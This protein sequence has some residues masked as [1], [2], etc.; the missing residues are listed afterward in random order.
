MR[1]RT[2]NVAAEP[3]LKEAMSDYVKDDMEVVRVCMIE[4]DI[5]SDEDLNDDPMGHFTSASAAM[6][7]AP[8][9]EAEV[10]LHGAQPVEA[11]G[12]SDDARRTLDSIA[13]VV[14]LKS[15]M[16]PS[17]FNS[18][19]SDWPDYKFKMEALFGI[20]GIPT[21]TRDV[22][23]ET[24]AKLLLCALEPSMAVR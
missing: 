10:P 22:Q 2:P 13:R 23:S 21:E 18:K 3:R 24:E 14:D 4:P 1:A 17:T 19:P 6:G 5:P 15:M 11:C 7:E 8:L 9:G 12:S 16:K 20:M